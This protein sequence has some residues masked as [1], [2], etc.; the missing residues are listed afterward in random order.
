M[1]L[2]DF[3]RVCSENPVIILFYFIAVP[4]TAALA[5][6]L[7]RNQGH[8]SPWK[9]LYSALIYLACVP[10]IFAL[11]LSAYLFLFEQRSIMETNLY[12]QILPIISMVLTIWLIKKNV[13]LD[14]VPGFD[15]LSGLLILIAVIIVIMW[16]LDKT[17]IFALTYIPLGYAVLILVGLFV[18]ARI[19]MSR[20]SS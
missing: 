7:G 16:I 14:L 3:F 5:W 17:R 18:L 15:K 19:G 9:Y 2:G 4:M 10:G 6:I 1:T 8:V 12:T 13:D 11:S 20:L